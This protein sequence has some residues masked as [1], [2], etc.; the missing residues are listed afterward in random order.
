MSKFS[1]LFDTFWR[2]SIVIF[3]KDSQS[4]IL[5]NYWV[6]YWNCILPWSTLDRPW[7]DI[8]LKNTFFLSAQLHILRCTGQF[9]S[10]ELNQIFCV[11]TLYCRFDFPCI[12]P[13]SPPLSIMDTTAVE[14]I[15]VPKFHF[16][17]GFTFFEMIFFR[18]NHSLFFQ[19]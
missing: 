4:N 9:V 18:G 12:T 1:C 16:L 5:S 19:P 14:T 11:Y 15:K 3:P 17:I 6:C 8:Y 7:E 13:L 10:L 2:M